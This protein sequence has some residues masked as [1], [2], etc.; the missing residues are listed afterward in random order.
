MNYIW[1]LL[2]LGNC[3]CGNQYGNQC[4]QVC[5]DHNHHN[6]HHH[7]HAC[8]NN[9]IQPR[10]PIFFENNNRCNEV[11]ECKLTPPAWQEHTSGCNCN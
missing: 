5:H 4:N 7:S 2:L 3:C 6:C 8:D 11:D 9:L 10:Q 1:L